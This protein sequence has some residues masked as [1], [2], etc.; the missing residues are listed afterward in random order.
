MG[1][2]SSPFLFGSTPVR[3][4]SRVF[5][6]PG[7]S[8][9]SAGFDSDATN[10]GIEGEK[11][12]A[13]V[14]DEFVKKTRGAYVFHSVKLPGH[15]GD[16]DHVLIVGTKLVVIDSKNW[17][18]DS[19][20]AVM[21]DGETVLRDGAVFPGGK[22]KISRYM[23]D[24]SSYSGTRAEGLLVVANSR[25][26]TKV[27][28]GSG[29]DFVNLDGLRKALKSLATRAYSIEYTPEQL[30]FLTSRVVNPDFAG[31][32]DSTVASERR[33]KGAYRPAPPRTSAEAR[34][35]VEERHPHL[36]YVV[37]VLTVLLVVPT[38]SSHGAV[39]PWQYILIGLAFLARSGYLAIR[40]RRGAKMFL[41]IGGAITLF[42]AV[43]FMA[44][45][46]AMS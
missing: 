1:V 40:R 10:A 24:M 17:R 6:R 34:K 12:V 30:L 29:W 11:R 31:D 38:L 44:T 13:A 35:Q 19:S 16:I 37:A 22:V 45:V 43:L 28:P 23:S 3:T 39:R 20:Y 4:N 25:S 46:S 36:V 32:W 18:S 7:G 33:T 41:L 26:E 5:G 2:M 21:E 42:T 27:P 8:L 15:Y 14:L 9:N